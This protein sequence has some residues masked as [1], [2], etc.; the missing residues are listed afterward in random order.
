MRASPPTRGAIQRLAGRVHCNQDYEVPLLP[1]GYVFRFSLLATWG[2]PFYIGLDRI[3][4]FD[5]GGRPLD[6]KAEQVSAFPHSVNVCLPEN[7]EVMSKAVACRQVAENLAIRDSRVPENLVRGVSNV[8]EVA[9]ASWLAPLCASLDASD[10]QA[11]EVYIC[12]DKPTTISL[13][14]LWNYSKDSQRGVSEFEISVDDLLLYRGR[15]QEAASGQPIIFSND[16]KILSREKRNVVYCGKAEQTVLLINERQV[17]GTS[18]N[19]LRMPLPRGVGAYQGEG[20]DLNCRPTTAAP[21][22]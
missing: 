20:V 17:M 19:H 1:R 18:A 21:I 3:E 13:V 5:E 7:M 15:L 8:R 4:I 22:L 16:E 10:M 9:H 6:I 2:D 14:K 11:N 12:F